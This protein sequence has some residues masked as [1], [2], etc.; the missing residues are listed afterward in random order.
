M[1]SAPIPAG[2]WRRGAVSRCRRTEGGGARLGWA[3]G[4]AGAVLVLCCGGGLIAVIG[5]VVTQVAATN[6]QSRA[7]VSRYLDA[8]RDDEYDQAYELLCDE[9][10]G[11]AEPRTGSTARERGPQ[12]DPRLRDRRVRRLQ[13]LGLPVTEPTADGTTDDVT[14]LSQARTQ[15]DAQ[16]E[17]CG[18]E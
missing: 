14:L 17:I 3:L 1:L 11:G 18:R 13:R 15:S 8:L 4:I 7:V 9:R 12:E 6:E 10:A 2:P 16:L 5:L